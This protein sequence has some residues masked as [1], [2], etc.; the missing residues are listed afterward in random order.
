M[1][2]CSKCGGKNTYDGVWCKNCAADYQKE[3]LSK[4]KNRIKRAAYVKNIRDEKRR[5]KN[6]SR[7]TDFKKGIVKVTYK[8]QESLSKEE[9][10][11]NLRVVA[12]RIEL[13]YI[14]PRE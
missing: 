13:G 1:K 5:K 2:K 9:I 4:P 8:H 6:M 7:I 14:L 11:E 10:I 3:Y 12:N